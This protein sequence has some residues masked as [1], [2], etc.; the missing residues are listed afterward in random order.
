[1]LFCHSSPLFLEE[2]SPVESL[3]ILR[4]LPSVLQIKLSLYEV[5]R[6]HFNNCAFL[7]GRKL[8][9]SFCINTCS[10]FMYATAFISLR[11]LIAFILKS[12]P[13]GSVLSI[14]LDLHYSTFRDYL[15]YFIVL[16]FPWVRCVWI[17]IGYSSLWLRF[18][19]RLSTGFLST[20]FLGKGRTGPVV[21]CSSPALKKRGWGKR[22]MYPSMECL[23]SWSSGWQW[24]FLGTSAIYFAYHSVCLT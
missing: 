10:Y 17:W 2:W 18:L 9:G 1:M 3:Q 5:P 21:T 4:S 14:S 11:I 19:V 12:W 7:F 13:N 8:F 6:L 24:F 20:V 22:G 15:F 23:G 16:V